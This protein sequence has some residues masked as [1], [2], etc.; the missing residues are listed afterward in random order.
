MANQKITEL[1]RLYA[2]A[3]LDPEY[4]GTVAPDDLIAIVDV[5]ETTTPSGE[6]KKM[7]IADLQSYILSGSVGSSNLEV[8]TDQFLITATDVSNGYITSSQVPVDAT[9]MVFIIQH[10][11]G[12]TYGIDY[13]V[14][15]VS[16]SGSTVSWSG[17]GLDGEISGSDRVTLRYQQDLS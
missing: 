11:P 14:P 1:R 16:T 2:S 3:S 7:Q 17:L 4:G 10:A 9:D 13:T 6:T 12:Q 15:T 8:V 5:D